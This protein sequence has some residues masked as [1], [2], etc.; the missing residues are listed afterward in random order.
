MQIFQAC[1]TNKDGIICK[2]DIVK[3][4][5]SDTRVKDF[6]ASRFGSTYSM[7][8]CGE[9]EKQ[10][11]APLSSPLEILSWFLS[12]YH[13]YSH[14][15]SLCLHSHFYFTAG[16]RLPRLQRM[17]MTPRHSCSSSTQSIG[18]DVVIVIVVVMVLFTLYFSYCPN[19]CDVLFH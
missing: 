9:Q 6:F 16:E 11:A 10:T 3:A 15:S 19:V 5:R 4:L 12:F 2:A 17:F 14:R 18:Y 13:S 1:D 7:I 8:V